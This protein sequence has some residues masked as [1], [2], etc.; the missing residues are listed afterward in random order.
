MFLYVI[1]FNAF[2]FRSW[3]GRNH[4]C[5]GHEEI[6]TLGPM[7]RLNFT[8]SIGNKQNPLNF[9]LARFT[10]QYAVTKQN[11]M[12]PVPMI[13]HLDTCIITF[14]MTLSIKI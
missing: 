12:E 13:L 6:I 2:C 5:T 8:D 4:S 1:L 14:T 11:H 10:V 3:H 9:T 7:L